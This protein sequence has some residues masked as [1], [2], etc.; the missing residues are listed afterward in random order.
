MSRITGVMMTRT[1]ALIL[2]ETREL[3]TAAHR[4]A[5][6]GLCPELRHI[7]G[8]HAGWWDVDGVPASPAGKAIRPAF[9]LASARAA[10]AD[11]RSAVPAAIAVELTHDFSLLHDDV[12]DGDLTRRH[13][14]TAWTAFGTGQALLA[15]DALLAVAIGQ[16][17][18][19]EQVRVLTAAVNDLCAGQSADIAFEDSDDVDIA[20]CLTM[21][22]EKTGAL[23]GA[24]CQ[25]GAMAGGAGASSGAYRVFGRELGL[26]FQLVDDMLGIW[27]DPAVTGKPVGSDLAARKKSLPVVAALTSQTPAGAELAR[28]YAR[29]SGIDVGHAAELVE[30]AGGRAWARAEATRRTASAMRALDAA[31]PA[32]PGAAD[33]RILAALI[34]ERDS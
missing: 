9:A 17:G 34:T 30:Q 8:Y 24:A 31:C 18:D 15:G 2:S 3:T 20:R 13:Q 28:H 4:T 21:A 27:G 10:G 1:A 19:S 26:A 23:L 7:A 6:D 25:L 11:A 14:A 22:E 16:L 32:M 12:I 5:I 29:D 33:L